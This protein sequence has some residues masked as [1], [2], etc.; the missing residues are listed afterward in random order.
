MVIDNYKFSNRNI[1]SHC[2][3]I[4]DMLLVKLDGKR[5]YE[6]NEFEMEQR[7]HRETVQR[8]IHSIHTEII[9]IMKK[10]FEVCN[11]YFGDGFYLVVV[12][13][14]NCLIWW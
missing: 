3:K 5:V 9:D 12:S 13:I 8:K 4:S 14:G 7:R 1:G 6:G 11:D 2:R 10:T